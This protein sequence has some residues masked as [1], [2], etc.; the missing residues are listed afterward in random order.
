MRTRLILFSA[1]VFLAAC[2][3][4][5]ETTAPRSPVPSAASDGGHNTK[6]DFP[7]GP[8]VAARPAPAFSLTTVKSAEY[9]MDGVTVW[10]G[11]V[12]A[13]CPAGSKVTGG[14]QEFTSGW[15]AGRT[16]S[17]GPIGGSGWDIYVQ[18]PLGQS[19]SVQAIAV[20]IQ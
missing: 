11:H 6:L 2:S 14:G 10:D 8:G 13:I 12:T 17:S 15:F 19:A 3:N 7:P 4:D 20:C 9:F 16:V 18:V 1:L 5:A